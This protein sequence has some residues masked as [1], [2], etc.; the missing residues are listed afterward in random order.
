MQ[1]G[2]SPSH[3]VDQAVDCGLWNVVQLHFNGCAKLLDIG[4]NCTTLLYV[5]RR[6]PSSLILRTNR[7]CG[8]EHG[9]V[10]NHGRPPKALSHKG[11]GGNAAPQNLLPYSAQHGVERMVSGSG[12]VAV[13][14]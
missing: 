14:L 8:D 12:V 1:R 6:L 2:R 13:E 11:Q 5:I 4:G 7:A 3:R 10:R 9:D